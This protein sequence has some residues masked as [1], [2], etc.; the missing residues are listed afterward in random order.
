VIEGEETDGV[1]EGVDEADEGGAMGGTDGGAGA[2]AVPEK[3]GT[4][5]GAGGREDGSVIG[6]DENEAEMGEAEDEK[7]ERWNRTRCREQRERQE[8][9]IHWPYLVVISLTEALGLCIVRDDNGHCLQQFAQSLALR[10]KFW[11]K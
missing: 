4:D 8:R 1:E 2:V 9:E 5:D 3:T 7:R 11:E 6:D 10:L